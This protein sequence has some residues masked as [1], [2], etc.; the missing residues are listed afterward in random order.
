MQDI[1]TLQ[2]TKYLFKFHELTDE[3][4]FRQR[5]GAADS[6]NSE[7]HRRHRRL[8]TQCTLKRPDPGRGLASSEHKVEA[9]RDREQASHP[10]LR[11][12]RLRLA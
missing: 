8:D 9:E 6:S 5:S 11:E 7:V 12:L 3:M 10:L 2:N 4:L 1:K